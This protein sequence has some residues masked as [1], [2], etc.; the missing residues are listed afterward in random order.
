M[1]QTTWEPKSAK[2][3]TAEEVEAA[4]RQSLERRWAAGAMNIKDFYEA[5]NGGQISANIK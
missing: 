2:Q 3:M 1:V 4:H 5:S